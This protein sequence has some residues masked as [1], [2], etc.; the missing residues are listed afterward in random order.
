[1]LY[2]KY[3][4]RKCQKCLFFAQKA[5]ISEKDPNYCFFVGLTKKQLQQGMLSLFMVWIILLLLPIAN[6]I[7]VVKGIEV[8]MGPT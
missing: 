6:L 1:M 5:E 3:T 8:Q 7:Q 2:M 4:Y